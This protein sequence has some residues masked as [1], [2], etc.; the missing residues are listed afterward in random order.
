LLCGSGSAAMKISSPASHCPFGV[1]EE[2]QGRRTLRIG[3]APCHVDLRQVT[4]SRV[5]VCFRHTVAVRGL[6]VAAIE[7]DERVP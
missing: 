2:L 5:R 7:G 4:G 1:V 3:L 6:P